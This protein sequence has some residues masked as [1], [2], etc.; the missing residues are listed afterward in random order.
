[1]QNQNNH[2]GQD[3]AERAGT[4]LHTGG[5]ATLE[6][7]DAMNHHITILGRPGP[8]PAAHV[9]AAAT[10]CLQATWNHAYAYPRPRLIILD[11]CSQQLASPATA[12]YLSQIHR[13]A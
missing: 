2:S 7:Q 5:A 1:M 11:D 8:A 10:A 6:G 4:N 9:P 3:H 12:A 13:Q